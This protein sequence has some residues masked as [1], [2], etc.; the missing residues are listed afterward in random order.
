MHDKG[1]VVDALTT[2]RIMRPGRSART[3]QAETMIIEPRVI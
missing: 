3:F 2:I 1:S